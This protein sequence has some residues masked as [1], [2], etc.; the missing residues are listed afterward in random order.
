MSSGVLPDRG[1][2]ICRQ[3]E[4]II[5]ELNK[6]LVEW[7]D[8]AKL[9]LV[10]GALLPELE[11]LVPSNVFQYYQEYKVEVVDKIEGPYDKL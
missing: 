3:L 11:L 10:Y 7:R 5:V 1:T 8:K 2:I 6:P 4:E 9:I